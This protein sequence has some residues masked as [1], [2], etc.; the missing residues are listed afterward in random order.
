M[1]DNAAHKPALPQAEHKHTMT[2]VE[3]SGAPT[4]ARVIDEILG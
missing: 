1:H 4:L 2:G 3:Q